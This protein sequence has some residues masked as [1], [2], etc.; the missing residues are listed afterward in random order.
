MCILVIIDVGAF[1]TIF[2]ILQTSL[3]VHTLNR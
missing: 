2:T 3:M 1:S